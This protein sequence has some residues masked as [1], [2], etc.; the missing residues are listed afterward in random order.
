MPRLVYIGNTIREPEPN[1]PVHPWQE[2]LE[3]ARFF[4]NVADVKEL[5]GNMRLPSWLSAKQLM[6]VLETCICQWTATEV[7]P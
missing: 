3:A 5:E 7:K 2:S 4:H 1:S 6:G